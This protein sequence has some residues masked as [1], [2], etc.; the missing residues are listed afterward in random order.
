L[1]RRSRAG[2]VT[3]GTAVGSRHRIFFS[4]TGPGPGQGRDGRGGSRTLFRNWN[5]EIALRGS[6]GRT[7]NETMFPLSVLIELPRIAG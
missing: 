5:S 2:T 4:G 6:A 7:G 3:R 1:K